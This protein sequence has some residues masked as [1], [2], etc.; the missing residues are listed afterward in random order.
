MH[1]LRETI[2]R[3]E[4]GELSAKDL[5]RMLRSGSVP[6][7]GTPALMLD[8]LG[9]LDSIVA[10]EAREAALRL[11]LPPDPGPNATMH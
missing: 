2:L 5:A 11:W 6:Y 7:P 1:D 4:R 9:L 10:A 8:L 3:F